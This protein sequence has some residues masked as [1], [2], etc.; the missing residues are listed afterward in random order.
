MVAAMLLCG[1]NAVQAQEQ[2]PSNEI[3][4]SFQGIGIGSMPFSGS[5]SWNDQPGLDL[6]FHVGYTHWFTD[7]IGIHTGVRVSHMWYNQQISN[8][9]MNVSAQL[10]LSS[11]GLPGGST[12]TTVNL[13]DAATTIQ[14][15]RQYTFLEVP[16][17]LALRFN[18]VYFN[19]GV[20]LAKAV[21]ANADYNYTDP[22]CEIQALPDLGITMSPAVPVALDGEAG[23][24][25]KNSDMAKPFY[26]LLAA[27]AGYNFPLCDATSLAVG[28]YGRYA[29]FA[30]KPKDAVDA[31]AIQP[32]ATYRLAQP[33]TSTLVEKVGYYEVGLSVGVNFGLVNKKAKQYEEELTALRRVD[34]ERSAKL[35]DERAAREKAES[36][37]ADE[38]AAREKAESE[39]AAMKAARDKA[40]ADL[41]AC[42]A[43]PQSEAAASDS[44]S[45]V[46]ANKAK[47]DTKANKAK[48]EAKANK[49][50]KAKDEAKANKAKDEAKA[51]KAKD[52]AAPAK[53]SPEA[54]KAREEAIRKL[55]PIG[56]TVY[57]KRAGTK[58]N[59]DEKNDDNIHAICNA[60]KA[61]DNLQ[62][63]VYGHADNTGTSKVNVKYGQKRAEALKNYMVKLGAPAKNIE[64]VSKGEDEPVADNDTKEGRALNRRATVSLK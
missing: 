34:N 54:Q 36:R 60:M 35:A 47:N 56:A 28:V 21:G 43:E 7:I 18:K 45:D 51:N 41:E 50:N 20:A 57:F 58:A 37:V 44:K 62:V 53:L 26:C 25:V 2:A 38:R 5:T 31:Y 19:V 13:R 3:S 49:A 64:C 11:L 52:E 42:Q 48:D 6:G 22:T 9:D 30:N 15:K 63:T 10:P 4:L 59:I 29:P 23:R 55:G 17:E 33:A 14:E 16:I 24:K 1:A 46:K 40:Q 27:E 32:D 61:D 39:L 8:L 12:T